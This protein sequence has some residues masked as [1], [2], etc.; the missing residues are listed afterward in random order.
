MNR[1][2][3]RTLMAVKHDTRYRSA[4]MRKAT[5]ALILLL[6]GAGVSTKAWGVE[7]WRHLGPAPIF[8]GT[9]VVSGRVDIAVSDPTD[10]NV[11]YVGTG[12]GAGLPLDIVIDPAH[13][14]RVFIQT[15]GDAAQGR[16]WMTDTGGLVWTKLDSGIPT[17]LAVMSLAVDWR[18]RHPTL[19]A[20]TARGVF[21]STDLG[22]N[23]AP[24]GQGLPRTIVRGL[25]I[26][27]NNGML[28]AATFGRGVY[29]T[30]L[31]IPGR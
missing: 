28:V 10:A 11:M 4:R 19:Y 31:A 5:V 14:N 15:I 23:W 24:F 9:T 1:D 25:Q 22:M 3:S 18:F 27:P 2:L 13:P 16:I 17:N 29:Q 30:R 12:A 21:F 20:G 7:T 6:F 26:L 8:N